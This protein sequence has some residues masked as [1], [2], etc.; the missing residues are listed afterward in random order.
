[1]NSLSPIERMQRWVDENL[2]FLGWWLIAMA[3]LVGWGFILTGGEMNEGMLLF[4]Q[5][6]TYVAGGILL[7][8]GSWLG[9]VQLVVIWRGFLAWWRGEDQSSV[10][11]ESYPSK[12]EWLG[13]LIVLGLCLVG[14]FLFSVEE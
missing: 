8:A 2:C 9:A 5:V 10:D 13:F 12:K 6:L 4:L 14:M 3:I 1:M 11:G 7:L